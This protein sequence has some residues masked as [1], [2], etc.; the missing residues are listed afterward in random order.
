MSDNSTSPRR[1]GKAGRSRKRKSLKSTWSI[2]GF[3]LKRPY[4]DFPLA[5]HFSGKWQKRIR[6]H[7]HYFARWAHMVDGKLERVEG[8]GWKE[9]LEIYK[10]QADDLHAG[11]TPKP[12]A[13]EL[14]V[15]V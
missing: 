13:D 15:A 14:T 7:I 10:A 4:P 11:R 6:G 5:P 1:S 3:K 2:R 9:A 8:D 12:K